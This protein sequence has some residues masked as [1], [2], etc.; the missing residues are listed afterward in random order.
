VKLGTSP[1]ALDN[2]TISGHHMVMKSVRIADLKAHL[3]RHLRSVRAGG[4]IAVLDRD[5]PVARLVPWNDAGA[6]LTVRPA[7]RRPRDVPLP[8]PLPRACRVPGVTS[9]DLLREDRGSGR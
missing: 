4:T 3:S 8:P 2:M 1:S 7:T 5:T 6:L 9:L